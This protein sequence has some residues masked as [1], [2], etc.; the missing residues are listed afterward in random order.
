[1]SVLQRGVPKPMGF[2][3]IICVVGRFG[4]L[5]ILVIACVLINLCL[6]WQALVKALR[7]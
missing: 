2:N 1:M 4:N 7:T 5:K 6:T 3:A